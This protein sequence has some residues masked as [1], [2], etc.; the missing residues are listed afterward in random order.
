MRV[1]RTRAEL[2]AALAVTRAGG[3]PASLVPTMGA[4]HA[5]H[6]ALLD[7]VGDEVVRVVSVFVNPVQFGPGEDLARYP[8]DLDQDVAVCAAHGVDV[9]FAP[10][11]E[12]IYPHREP[13][14]WVAPG[15]LGGVLEGALRPGHFR[16]VLTVVAVLLGLVRPQSVVFGEKDYQQLVLVRRMV[17]DLCLGVEVV[18]VATVRAPDGVALSSRNRYLSAGQRVA[19]T[20]LH[21]ALRAGVAAAPT[22]RAAVLAAAAAVLAEVPDVEPDYLELCSPELGPP[23]STGPARLLVAARVGSTRLLDNTALVLR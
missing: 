4:L 22:G 14:V 23:P 12:E 15:P 5:G 18:A 2:E 9:V 3:A 7:A 20:A 17:A 10:E 21:R 19:A 13:R 11:V 6:E 16:G 8:R 1:A